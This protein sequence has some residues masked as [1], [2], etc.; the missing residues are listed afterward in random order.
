MKR[1]AA[2]SGNAL[3]CERLRPSAECRKMS[4]MR[5]LLVNPPATCVEDDRMEP[6]LGLLYVA[7]RAREAGYEDVSVLDMSGCSSEARIAASIDSLPV[8]DVYGLTCFCTNYPYAKKIVAQARKIEPRAGIVI[9]GPQASG[10]PEFTLLDSGADAVVVGEGEDAFTEYVDSVAWGKPINGT[11]RGQPRA[12]IDSYPFPARDLVDLSTYSRRILGH[13][14]ISLISSR[15]CAHR[16]THCNS[17]VMGG[18][19]LSA[20]YRSPDNVAHEVQ[21][22]RDAY[23]HFRFND[24]HFTGNRNLEA[25]LERLKDLDIVFRVFARVEDLT[26]RTCALLKQA[27]CVLVSIGLESLNPDN[28][29]MLGKASQAGK[30]GNVAIARRRGL[31]TR[32]SFI[33]GLPYDSDRS[34]EENFTKAAALGLDEFSVYA[35]I[36]YPGTAIARDPAKFGYTIVHTDF[37][38][39]VQLGKGRRTC[40]ALQHR[41]FG[42]H[43]VRRWKKMA[44]AVLESGGCN[45]MK[46]SEV[47]H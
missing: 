24:D 7:A 1:R 30:E 16:C 19:S 23:R 17:V 21:S 31:T 6:P 37:T 10:L 34:I 29:K 46:K 4:D 20:R 5:I 36:P 8:A 42:P 15:G 39:Y 38:D 35:L 26:E 40:C 11:L 9:G 41:N 33:V 22:L 27:G 47:A 32:A 44:E 3:S 18:G 13:P 12:D 45:H 14:T 25:L 2:G 43:D 28:L